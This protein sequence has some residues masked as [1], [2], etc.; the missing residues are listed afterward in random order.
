MSLLNLY[1]GI[2]LSKQIVVASIFGYAVDFS[3]VLSIA[4]VTEMEMEMEMARIP[5]VL[6]FR[7]INL[8]SPFDRLIRWLRGSGKAYAVVPLVAAVE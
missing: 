3:E 6:A 8:P 1:V 2:C 4:E 7:Y 5:G